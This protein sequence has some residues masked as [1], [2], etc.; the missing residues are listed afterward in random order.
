MYMKCN[1]FVVVISIIP[2]NNLKIC[3]CSFVIHILLVN[4]C[5]N[6]MLEN[7]YVN[8]L[9]HNFRVFSLWTHVPLTLGLNG[10][11]HLTEP[12][13]QPHSDQEAERCKIT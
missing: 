10:R 1:F 7:R 3:L 8:V 13:F 12:S 6:K 5:Y 11:K 9:V 4:Y 2:V